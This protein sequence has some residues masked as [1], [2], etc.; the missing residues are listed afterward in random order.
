MRQKRQLGFS[1]TSAAPCLEGQGDC[2]NDSQCL[3]D[4]ECSPPLNSGMD[5]CYCPASS[6]NVGMTYLKH[7]RVLLALGKQFELIF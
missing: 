2:D 6:C 4:L 1:C 3:G 5:L 7:Y